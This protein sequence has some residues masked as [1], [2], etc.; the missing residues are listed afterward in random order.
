MGGPKLSVLIASLVE[1]QTSLTALLDELHAQQAKLA[2]PQD[3]EILVIQDARQRTIG[4]KRNELLARATGEYLCFIDDDDFV[5]PNYLEKILEALSTNP[6][7]V[8]FTVIITTNWDRPEFRQLTPLHRRKDAVLP[9]KNIVCGLT[10]L[11]PIKVTIAK[12]VKFPLINYAE[13]QGWYSEI[14]PLLKTQACIDEALY[15]YNFVLG[16]PGREQYEPRPAPARHPPLEIDRFGFIAANR[17]RTYR[18]EPRVGAQ[19]SKPVAVK[20]PN[21]KN[22]HLAALLVANR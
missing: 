16:K 12:S 21:P 1:R 7:A 22:T 10:H 20:V 19:L 15:H 6:D 9:N 18:P 4:D 8:G 17:H 11:C 2:N 14:R 3:V 5:A 13:D